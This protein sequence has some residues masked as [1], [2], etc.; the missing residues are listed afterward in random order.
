[1]R[2]YK[3]MIH[4]NNKQ[5]TKIRKTLN[6]C[7][8]CQ[9]IVYDY[10]DS[11]LTKGDKIPSCSDVRKWFTIQKRLKDEETINERINMT[12]K[13]MI[14]NH[15]DTLFYDISNDALKQMVKDTYNSFVRFF[16]KLGKYPVRKSYKDRKKSFYVDPYKIDFTDKKVRLEKISNNQK[17]NRQVLNYINMAEKNR[18]PLGVKYYNP[19]VSYDGTNFF[20]TVGVD[21]EYTPVKIR[22]KV[23][24][25]VIGIDLNNGKI[26][27]S[28]NISYPQPTRD[29]SYQKTKKRKKRLQRALS[30]KY[31]VC[32]PESKKGFKLSKNYK[33]NKLLVIKLDKRLRNIKEQKHNQIISHILSKPPKIIVLE[34]LHIKEMS[35][36]DSRMEKTYEE[37]QASKNITEAS[38]R[39]FRMMLSNRAIKHGVNIIIA[40]QYYPSSQKC[41]ICG[42][43]K[44]MK[45]DKRIYKC[46]QCGLII[47]R[48]LNAAIN[49]ANYIK[50]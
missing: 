31:L 30:R 2:T 45:V 23:D 32:N 3:V 11:F 6:K 48:D 7:I 26:V 12:K 5:A 35:K 39:K 21:D 14:S 47:D 42:N 8:E 29:S 9:N 38:M 41:S 50:K 20:I 46:E 22:N 13:E 1:M 36:R 18:I 49:L 24:D 34:D 43:L 44:E 37:K 28:D 19:R 17:P 40:N 16:K 33:K 15:L 27:T 4:P 25:R 10:L